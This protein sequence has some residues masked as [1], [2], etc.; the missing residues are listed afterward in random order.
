MQFVI[1]IKFYCFAGQAVAKFC[2][3]Y[4]HQQVLR[5]ESY[6]SGDL[7]TSLQKAFLRLFHLFSL[8]FV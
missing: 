1:L 5:Q 3:K 8:Y 6:L 7:G 4:L 2:A